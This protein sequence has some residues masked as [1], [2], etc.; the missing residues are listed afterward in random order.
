MHFL[1]VFL[2]W[3]FTLAR[4]IVP[5]YLYSEARQRNLPRPLWWI[6][7]G[8]FEPIVAIIA[9]YILLFFR[10]EQEKKRVDT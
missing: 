1:P 5:L 8:I 3:S 2:G 6:F 4:I 10:E 7:F 9:L